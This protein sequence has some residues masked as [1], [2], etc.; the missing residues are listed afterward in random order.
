MKELQSIAIKRKNEDE[1]DLFSFLFKNSSKNVSELIDRTWNID[2]APERQ[3]NKSLTR[4][5]KLN[6]LF[7]T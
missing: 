3:Q 2:S 7:S 6:A 5:E 4:T 1:K